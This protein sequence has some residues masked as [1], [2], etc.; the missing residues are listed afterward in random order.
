MGSGSGSG[1]HTPSTE[2]GII[3]TDKHT[4]THIRAGPRTLEY[5]GGGA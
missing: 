1:F 4:H 5:G 3:L 2:E